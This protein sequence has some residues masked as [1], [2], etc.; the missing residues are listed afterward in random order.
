[1]CERK[2]RQP[3]LGV[4]CWRTRG[5]SDSTLTREYSNT[6]TNRCLV[7][8]L[9]RPAPPLV[10][11]LLPLLLQ[12]LLLLLRFLRGEVSEVFQCVIP[13][14]SAD[15]H[16]ASCCSCAT[17]ERRTPVALS[18]VCHGCAGRFADCCIGAWARKSGGKFC[19]NPR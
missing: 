3:R 6:V 18:S 19:L 10:Q 13:R 5:P 8:V 4:L 12:V 14:G 11:L 17:F 16:A 7:G 2:P 1:M 15:I 9:M